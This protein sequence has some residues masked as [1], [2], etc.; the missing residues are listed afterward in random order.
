MV[1]TSGTVAA[2]VGVGILRQV[3]ERPDSQ[4]IA[5]VRY[6]DTA[7]LDNRIPSI[8]NGEWQQ[9]RIDPRHMM[10]LYNNRAANPQLD[11]MLYDGLLPET[12]EAGGG[13]IRDNGAGAL[14]VNRKSLLQWLSTSIAELARSDDSSSNISIA[15]ILSSVGATGSGPAQNLIE[16]IGDAAY[17]A[18]IVSIR[19]DMFVLQPGTDNMRDLGLANTLALYSELAGARLEQEDTDIKRF[20][21][22]I[23]MVGWGT[24]SVL[25]KIRPVAKHSGYPGAA[26]QRP[27]VRDCCRVSGARGR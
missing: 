9:M 4:L 14:L 21:G 16:L 8:L 10:V 25:A 19:C 7:R 18:K 3:S 27:C 13:Q 15:L 24:S 6:I 1:I 2:G 23:I 12:T 22:R 26:H 11:Q 17:N 20:Q 5:R